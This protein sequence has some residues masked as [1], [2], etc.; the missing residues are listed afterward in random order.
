MLGSDGRPWELL[1]GTTLLVM[2]GCSEALRAAL[3]FPKEE[4]TCPLPLEE[5]C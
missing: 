2:S 5:P 1:R 4:G 3:K